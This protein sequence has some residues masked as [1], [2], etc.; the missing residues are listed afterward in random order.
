M[1][2]NRLQTHTRDKKK[3]KTKGAIFYINVLF[4][5]ALPFKIKVQFTAAAQ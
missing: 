2:R 4:I 1:S 5:V 3:Q